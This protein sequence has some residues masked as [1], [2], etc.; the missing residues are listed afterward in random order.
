MIDKKYGPFPQDEIEFYKAR[1]FDE[2]NDNIN[3]FQR[4]LVFNLFYKYFGDTESIKAINKDDYIK[5]V[6]AA[7]NMLISNDMVVLP[8]VISSKVTKSIS[9]KNINKKEEGK[10]ESCEIFS[11]IMEK[12][13]YKPKIK[14]YILSLIATIFSSTINMIDYHDPNIDGKDLPLLMDFIQ[15]EVCRY[16]RLI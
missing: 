2:E 8:Y 16:V 5:L 4:N 3:T 14:Q 12:Y 7:K 9:R 15:E 1:L 13:S 10:V 11:E 6:I